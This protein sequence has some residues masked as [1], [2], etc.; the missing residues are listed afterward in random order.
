[1]KLIFRL[2]VIVALLGASFYLGYIRAQTDIIHNVLEDKKD[3]YDL[4]DLRIIINK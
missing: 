3:C 4:E 2:L 1:M